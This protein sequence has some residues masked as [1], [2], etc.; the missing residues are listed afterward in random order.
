MNPTVISAGQTGADYGAL[1]AARELK[2]NIKGWANNGWKTQ[3]G[4]NLELTDWGLLENQVASYAS[5]DRKNVDL[6]DVLIAF[7]YRISETGRGTSC[8]VNYAL[9]KKYKYVELDESQDYKIYEGK[10]PAIVFWDLNEKNLEN[11]SNILHDFLS[12]Y[13]PN[14][15][16][17]T[18]P[19]QSTIECEQLIKKLLISSLK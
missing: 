13:Q 16:M 10:K 4:P 5:T 1:L 8:T 15:I 17:I 14:N 19:C 6:T 3:N 2:L 7:R 11:F 12:K 9:T 18:G